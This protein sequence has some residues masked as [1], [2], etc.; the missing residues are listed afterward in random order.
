MKLYLK[1]TV[2]ACGFLLLNSTPL[3]AQSDARNLSLVECYQLARKH[4]PL[5]RNKD[6]I[7]QSAAYN[8]E[9]ASK[10]YLPQLSAG[11]QA[12]YQSAVTQIP[13]KLPNVNIQT[14]SKDQY[15]IYAEVYQPISETTVISTQKQLIQLNAEVELAKTDIDIY[16]IYER[17]QQLYFGVLLIEAQ[18]AQIKLVQNDLHSAAEKIKTAI[19]F[20][21]ALKSNA[22]VL[23]AEIL[24]TEQKEI[25]LKSSRKAYIEMLAYFIN[26]P[27]SEGVT[28]QKPIAL[29]ISNT[30]KT[31]SFSLR[32]ELNLF[33]SQYKILNLQNRYLSV[34]NLPRLGFF[35]QGG[36][37]RPALNMLNN[38]FDFY[39]IGGLRFSWNFSGLYT[40]HTD[41]KILQVQ[42]QMIDVQKELFIFNT[43]LQARQQ[44]TELDRWQQLVEKDNAIVS[45]RE[46]VKNITKTQLE[47]GTASVYDFTRDL[48]AEDQARQSK[49]M[50][51]IQWLM[52]QYTFRNTTGFNL[53][54]AE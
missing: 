6:L 50:H 41:R 44:S 10:G 31:D 53:N 46:S 22:D 18:Q 17:I 26:E 35:A 32:P 15:K 4:F 39:Y 52:A 37:G 16:K 47:N 28:L 7:S 13:I 27:L 23:E 36:Y 49:S 21:T 9:N 43:G 51:E 20:G 8:L 38:N 42:H 29:N 11:G 30:Q 14:L 48:N 19:Q 12:S 34:K 25:E 2:W 1:Q 40:L 33:H 5:I 54:T 3:Q 24:K 45:L